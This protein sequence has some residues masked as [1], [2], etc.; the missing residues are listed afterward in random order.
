MSNLLHQAEPNDHWS[1]KAARVWTLDHASEG[2]VCPCCE[3]HVKI[4][5]RKLNASMARSLLWLVRHC[6]V[7]KHWCDVPRQAPTWLL[8]SR[9][10]PKLAY[11]RLVETQPNTDDPT[12]R[13]SGIWR[14]TSEGRQFAYSRTVVPSHAEIYNGGVVG[15]SDTP[16]T[17]R[18]ALGERFDYSELMAV[19]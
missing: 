18:E 9:E 14:P 4:Y 8:R 19:D 11:W 2:T 13:C 7:T 3:Q 12:K 5:R 10:L 1:L 15:Y 6:E 16:T 17:I